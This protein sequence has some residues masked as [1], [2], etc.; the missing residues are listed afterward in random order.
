[1]FMSSEPAD[2][3]SL[4]PLL[5]RSRSESELD[6]ATSIRLVAFGLTS[7]SDWWASHALN[8]VDQ[9]VMADQVTEALRLCAQNDRYSQQTRHRA[10]RYL[11]ARDGDTA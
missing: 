9:G 10:W 2:L 6:A 4:L 5:E 3:R 11:K 8:W 1:V 7:W